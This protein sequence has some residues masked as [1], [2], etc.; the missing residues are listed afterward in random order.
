MTVSWLKKQP[1]CQ[2]NRTGQNVTVQV[3]ALKTALQGKSE[4][5]GVFPV[6]VAG[7]KKIPL[8]TSS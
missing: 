4:D 6:L 1:N 8:S 7:N 3:K 5:P 2:T